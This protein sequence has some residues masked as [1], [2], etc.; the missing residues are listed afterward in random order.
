[1]NKWQNRVEIDAVKLKNHIKSL[2]YKT[3]HI[4]IQVGMS[5]SRLYQALFNDKTKLTIEEATKISDAIDLP[6]DEFATR[7]AP[8]PKP[9]KPVKVKEVKE[10]KA[11]K[12]KGHV[13]IIRFKAKQVGVK[14]AQI[15]REQGIEADYITSQ[16]SHDDCKFTI[17]MLD[18]IAE[19]LNCRISEIAVIPKKLDI[20]Y[21]PKP[22][23]A[24]QPKLTHQVMR[25][26]NIQPKHWIPKTEISYDPKLDP[27]YWKNN[28]EIIPEKPISSNDLIQPLIE[29][30]NRH[31]EF[32]VD[33]MVAFRYENGHAVLF[34]NE[35]IPSEDLDAAFKQIHS[36]GEQ[37]TQGDRK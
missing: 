17:E 13:Q 18:L 6:F 1:M 35:Y 9:S 7:K 16:L 37:V 19:N 15:C 27:R 26:K 31:T 22:I 21:T 10:S 5:P 32:K 23:A 36:W 25:P 11:V 14:F 2:N 34:A 20:D 30:P 12:Y 24:S 8:Q 29:T 28:V 3:A 33:G 4:A